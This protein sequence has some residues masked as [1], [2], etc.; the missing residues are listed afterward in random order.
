MLPIKIFLQVEAILP[1]NK[2]ELGISAK[3]KLYLLTSRAKHFF[4][5]SYFDT[6]PEVSIKGMDFK[7]ANA[8]KGF[9]ATPIN[10]MHIH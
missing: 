3:D 5:K 8:S 7:V 10:L 9:Q 6:S 2:P 1:Q 4:C